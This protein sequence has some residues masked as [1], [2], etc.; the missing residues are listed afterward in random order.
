MLKQVFY[1]SILTKLSAAVLKP[2]L[3]TIKAKMD[4]SEYGGAP[5][6][7]IDG[8]AFKAHGSSNALTIENAI[9]AARTYKAAGINEKIKEL[10]TVSQ[11]EE[12][13]SEA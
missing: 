9:R 3:K 10:V 13:E 4:Y 12:K 5:F 8:V 1:K 2:G 6:L 7:G 11:A